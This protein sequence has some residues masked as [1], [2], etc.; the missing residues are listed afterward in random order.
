LIEAAGTTTNA[1][2]FRRAFDVSLLTGQEDRACAALKSAP[3]LSPAP[4]AR[5]FCAAR[6]GDWATANLALRTETSLGSLSPSDSELLARFLDPESVAGD[7]PE[8]QKPLTPLTWRI[9]DALGQTIPAAGLPLAFSHAELGPRAGWK[10]QIE[11]A[12]RL[13]RA[14][15]L[16]PN[17]LLGLYTDRVPAAS[18]GVW[19]RADAFQRF[20]AALTKGDVAGVTATLPAAYAMMKSVELEVPFATLYADALAK[21]PLTGAAADMAYELGLLSPHYEILSQNP[22]PGQRQAFLAGLAA[23]NLAGL[24]APDSMG[25]AIAPAFLG[26]DVPPDLADLARSGQT[27]Q[28]ILAAIARINTGVL[29]EDR[30]ITEGL[31]LLRGLGLESVARQVA[32]DLMILERRG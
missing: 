30:A 3:G 31:A 23:G 16:A 11:A 29:G 20:D 19:D 32:L 2:L 10:A 15:V 13:A 17:L 28:A 24:T 12:E 6:S 26:T 14:D 25:R 9:Y 21:L 18:G 4:P 22:P 1:D 5:I 27:G 8:P 7:M